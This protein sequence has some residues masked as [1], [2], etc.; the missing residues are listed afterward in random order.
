[1]IEDQKVK[2]LNIQ[3]AKGILTEEQL[4]YELGF[5]TFSDEENEQAWKSRKLWEEF[6]R[7]IR[8]PMRLKRH[9]QVVKESIKEEVCKE[10]GGTGLVQDPYW[11]DG[12][13]MMRCP[14]CRGGDSNVD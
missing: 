8:Q 6:Q 2:T 5:N 11:E 3:W 14:S 13:K 4:Y 7:G 12:S 1:M 10:C 9:T